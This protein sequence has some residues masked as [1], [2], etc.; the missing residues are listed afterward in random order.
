MWMVAGEVGECKGCKAMFPDVQRKLG[1]LFEKVTK[2][3]R[4]AS[5]SSYGFDRDGT[6]RGGTWPFKL[7]YGFLPATSTERVRVCQISISASAI[8]TRVRLYS[9]SFSF[10]ADLKNLLL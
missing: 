5:R 8:I 4:G 6:D 2:F 1:Q 7:F 10:A 9:R 3:S